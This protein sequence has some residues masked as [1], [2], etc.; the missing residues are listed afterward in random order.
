MKSDDYQ[1]AVKA[2]GTDP[3]AWNWQASDRK[4]GFLPNED[5]KELDEN[6]EIE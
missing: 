2:K 5:E 1:K 3:A 6:F 4:E